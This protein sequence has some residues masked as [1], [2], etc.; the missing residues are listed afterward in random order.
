M[1]VPVAEMDHALLS[2]V[3]VFR[4]IGA[5]LSVALAARGST[6]K[7]DEGQTLF[8]EGDEAGGFYIVKSG[9]LKATRLSSEG[10]EQLLAVFSKGDAIGE[11]GMFDD[12]PRSASITALR[13]SELIHWPKAGFFRFADECPE[14]YRHLL[15]V[16]SHR[17][18]ETNDSLAARDFLPL[19]GQL[20]QVMLRLREGFGEAMADETTRIAHRLTQAE[21]ASMIG[22][23]RENVSRVINAW[24]RQGILGREEG[25]YVVLD[26]DALLALSEGS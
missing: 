7:V 16:L 11:M 1:E 24:K 19:A 10:G 4:G 13:K 23:S 9:G 17:L 20:A 21:L 14:L 8:L 25:Y 18:R 5:D 6:I 12:E 2:D 15:G 26:E 22:A 3:S